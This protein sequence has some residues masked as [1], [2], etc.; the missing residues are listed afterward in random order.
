MGDLMGLK[1]CNM[2]C[3]FLSVHG[4]SPY[5]RDTDLCLY[6]GSMAV[7][8]LGALAAAPRPV[9][10][11]FRSGGEPEGNMVATLV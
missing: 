1:G 3:A 8:V 11:H 7:C 4:G 5:C 2:D 9:E 10:R 6:A